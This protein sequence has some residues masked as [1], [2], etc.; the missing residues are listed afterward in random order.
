[1]QIKSRVTD[2]ALVQRRRQQI[3]Q[4]AVDLFSEQGYYRT[5]V[6]EIAGK[7]G[8]STGLIYQ[9]VHDKEDIL[10]LSILDVI[11]S[12][13]REIPAAQE[14]LEDPLQ[15]F[16]MAVTTYC[17]VVDARREATVLAY[18]STKSLPA[19]RRRLV[20][21]AE[22]ET[23]GLI[24]ESIQACVDAGLFRPLDVEFLTYQLVMFAH[25]WAL[26]HWR[27]SRKYDL[28]QYIRNGFWLYIPA[29]LSDEGWRHF[30]SAAE[31]FP[32]AVGQ[33]G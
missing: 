27:L 21:A 29:C 33:P 23:N 15:R 1:M 2:E 24:A 25:S 19:D 6:Q 5:T 8:V 3:A 26:K 11:E 10:L 9:Y 32:A 18:R 30:R 13:R 4:A 22:V 14:G 16:W 20:M 28:E 7:A 31:Q 17:R 12:Y